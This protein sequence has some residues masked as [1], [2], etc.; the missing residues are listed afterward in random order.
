[1][2]KKLKSGIYV[3]ENIINGHK[4]IGSAINIKERW[5]EHIKQLKKNT[6]H[7]Q[8]LQ[9]AWNLYGEQA[10]NFLVLETC[11]FLNLIEKEQQYL[12]LYKPE[13]NICKYAGS[14]LGHKHSEE[15]KAK[16]GKA[17][18]GRTHTEAT[19]KKIA[20]ANKGNNHNLGR[21][22]SEETK[23]KMSLARKGKHHSEETKQQISIATKGRTVSLE[24]RQKLSMSQ[25][26][27]HAK[28]KK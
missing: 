4:Y 12:D 1:M 21:T 8:H 17:S 16:I 14:T 6:H 18:V 7:S 10:F 13:Y 5:N 27:H 2:N 15:T 23:Q 25:K 3:I 11:F 26:A 22:A 20:K 9:N 24:T 28:I 19:K